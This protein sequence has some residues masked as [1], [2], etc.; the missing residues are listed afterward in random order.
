MSSYVYLATRSY[1]RIPVGAWHR[2][3]ELT[4][5]LKSKGWETARYMDVWRIRGKD[6]KPVTHEVLKGVF[7]DEYRVPSDYTIF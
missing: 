1:D 7:R 2:K 4:N 6:V 5:F 3:Y